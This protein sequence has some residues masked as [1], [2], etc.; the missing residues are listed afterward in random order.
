MLV[1]QA[2]STAARQT[3][4]SLYGIS[5]SFEKHP[6]PRLANQDDRAHVILD[7]SG[8]IDQKI[9]AAHCHRTQHALFVRRSSRAAGKPLGIAEVL[10]RVE[11]LHRF[12]PAIASAS[13]EPL[14]SFLEANC[15]AELLYLGQNPI[16]D[17]GGPVEA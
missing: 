4:V 8:W 10:M 15:D 9:E 12:L 11:S 7:V 3:S 16:T 17:G 14:F 5:A 6:R 2:V 1:H 13:S